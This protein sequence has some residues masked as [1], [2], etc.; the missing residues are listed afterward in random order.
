[1]KGY[2][3]NC[4]QEVFVIIEVKAT[5][6]CTYIIEDLNDEKIVRMFYKTELQKTN[7]T[8]FRAKKVI[9]KKGSFRLRLKIT[10]IRLTAG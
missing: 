1:M 2:K 7:Q 9:K 6:P 3:P 10:K 4:S 8:E 5:V